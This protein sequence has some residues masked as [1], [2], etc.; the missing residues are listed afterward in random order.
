MPIIITVL[1]CYCFVVMSMQNRSNRT[2]VVQSMRNPDTDE[3]S[4]VNVR[5]CMYVCIYIERINAIIDIYS[6]VFIPARS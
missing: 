3:P 2:I 1:F 4:T 6:G 5:V